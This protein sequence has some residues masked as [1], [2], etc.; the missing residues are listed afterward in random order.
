M[1]SGGIVPPGVHEAHEI[2]G[3]LALENNVIEFGM[4]NVILVK[5]ASTAVVTR[6]PGGTR[7][8]IV[9]ALSNAIVDGHP[10]RL[11]RIAPT[12]GSRKPCR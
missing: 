3:V 6:L 1:R 11:Y 8:E 10:V 4:D 2:Q 12:M 7:E 9:N 5:I